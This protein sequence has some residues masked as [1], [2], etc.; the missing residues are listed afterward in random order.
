MSLSQF[1]RTHKL[2]NSVKKFFGFTMLLLAGG[3]TE[4]AQ[5]LSHMAMP[6]V[7]LLLG[8]LALGNIRRQERRKGH[9][10]RS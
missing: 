1:F 9:G 5:T 8:A 3:S 2:K 4:G 10:K 6:I 7:F